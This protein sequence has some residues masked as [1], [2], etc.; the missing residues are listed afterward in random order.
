[1]KSNDIFNGDYTVS[2]QTYLRMDG[3]VSQK[4]YTNFIDAASAIMK[5]LSEEGFEVKD[6]FYYLYTRLTAEV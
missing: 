1:M 6:I 2:N 3:L 4:D 5:E